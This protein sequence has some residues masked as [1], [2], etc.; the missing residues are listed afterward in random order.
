[1]DSI[2]P[3]YDVWTNL[4]TNVAYGLWVV[5][6]LIILGYFLRLAFTADSKN[7]YDFINRYEINVMWVASVIIILGACVFVNANVTEL[8]AR[9]IVA[10]VLLTVAMGLI[11]AL[12]I[13][14]LLKYYYPLFIEK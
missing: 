10:R 6:L 11:V 1:M 8:N 9:W 4:A 7:R 2:L 5:G 14:N 12:I 3:N 13:R